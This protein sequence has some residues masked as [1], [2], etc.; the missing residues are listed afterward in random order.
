MNSLAPPKCVG[1][2]CCSRLHWGAAQVYLFTF[3]LILLPFR[4]M[5]PLHLLSPLLHVVCHTCLLPVFSGPCLLGGGVLSI[6]DK[7]P[8]EFVYNMWLMI[9]YCGIW[10]LL[11]VIPQIVIIPWGFE[12]CSEH[13]RLGTH[14]AY[15][16]TSALPLG[17]L[18]YPALVWGK[19]GT[20]KHRL[21]ALALQFVA[22][23]CIY[24]LRANLDCSNKEALKYYGIMELLSVLGGV[25]NASRSP[26]RWFDSGQ[27]DLGLNSHQLMHLSAALAIVVM[28]LGTQVDFDQHLQALQVSVV[29]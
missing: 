4:L 2:A 9:D 8:Q 5:S 14:L 29:P 3:Y 21:G 27:L 10:L 18:L 13:Y 19:P 16:F 23:T 11:T 15:G 24:T 20:A 1:A 7:L 25:V 26:E 28:Y 12:N 22:R 6:A 17:I